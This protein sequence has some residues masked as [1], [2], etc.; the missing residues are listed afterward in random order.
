MNTYTNYKINGA[1]NKL[2]NEQK[3]ILNN[4]NYSQ[5]KIENCMAVL[6]KFMKHSEN[7]VV[8]R[9]S[10]E[11]YKLIFQDKTKNQKK[12][13]IGYDYFKAIVRNLAELN[14]I[15]IEKVG[16]YQ[17]VTIVR[18]T[19]NDE[20]THKKPCKKTYE[21]QA[22]TLENTIVE[23]I[24]KNINLFDHNT[25]TLNIRENNFVNEVLSLAQVSNK[26]LELCKELK[27]KKKS[28]VNLIT[29][30]IINRL[31][32]YNIELRQFTCHAYLLKCI[33]EKYNFIKQLNVT[34]YNY[35]V[36]EYQGVN[37][38]QIAEIESLAC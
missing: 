23:D 20:K 25:S 21:K 32:K 27:I 29:D 22:E 10:K 38:E 13:F 18:H 37:A 36:S 17:K 2:S 24:E 8:T 14:L 26:I 12:T 16:K 34:R 35:G 3:Q 6:G 28:T 19:S 11:I 30:M 33:F 15:T 4:S 9:P 1:S 5:K 31:K 7:N